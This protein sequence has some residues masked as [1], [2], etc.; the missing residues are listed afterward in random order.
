ME[1][2]D[3]AAGLWVVG[4]G[5][6]LDHEVVDEFGLEALAGVASCPAAGGAGGEHHA[7][8]GQ[9]A[10]RDAVGGGGAEG[11]HG[12]RPGDAFERDTGQQ[13]AGVAVEEVQDLHVDAGGQAV[14]GEVGLPHLVGHLGFE[15]QVGRAGPL[16]PP[17][18]SP[19]Q[20]LHR[21]RRAG[22]RTMLRVLT[23]ARDQVTSERTRAVNALTALL[24]T[25]D[26]GIDT[27]PG[28]VHHDHHRLAHLDRRHHDRGRL[29]GRSDRPLRPR[30]PPPITRLAA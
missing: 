12:H 22:D 13:V 11:C 7:V 6:F 5:V 2:F 30:R 27:P 21:S 15:P 8:V 3:L 4:R 25:V 14:V 29:P 17:A 23:T 18:A 19:N 28:P 24:R 9:G 1:A 20:Q 16:T 10:G 26:P